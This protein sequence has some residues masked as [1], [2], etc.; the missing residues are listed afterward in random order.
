MSET[1]A[2]RR[3]PLYLGERATRVL[4]TGEGSILTVGPPGTGKSRGLA[5]WNAGAFPGSLLVTDPKGELTRWSARRREGEGHN[6]AVLD[7][8]GLTG[9]RSESVNPLEPLIDAARAGEGLRI[10]VDR[11]AHL[12]LPDR[13][14]S[15]ESPFWR[16]GARRVLSAGLYYLAALDPHQCTLPGLQRVLWLGDREFKET[17]LD[18]MREASGPFALVLRQN[19]D[20]VASAFE[21]RPEHFSS[22]REDAREAVSIFASDEP[23]GRACER[24]TVDLADLS[25]GRLT[26]YLVLPPHLISSHGRWMGLVVNHAVHAL[27]RSPNYADCLFLLDE[28][29]NLGKLEPIKTAVALLRG[30]GLRVWMFVQDLAQLDEVYGKA[31]A[32]SFR[33]QAEVLQVLGCRSAELAKFIET[34]AGETYEARIKPTEPDPRNPQGFWSL[35]RDWERRPMLTQDAI[36]SMPLG[37]QILIRHGYPVTLARLNYW[38]E[39]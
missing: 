23:V 1:P 36:L 29:A 28:F 6:V 34:R 13:P 19:A 3:P 22:F 20:A 27:M 32:H 37:F 30:K 7:P 16:Q 35:A 15:N 18:A 11:I 21:E 24:S 2:G 38:E 17:V 25:T 4:Y 26:V 14:S 8:F 31:D 10:E 9:R 12:L 33:N 5:A 39:G